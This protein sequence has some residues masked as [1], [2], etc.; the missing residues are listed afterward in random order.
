M[1]IG[2]YANQIWQ[3]MMEVSSIRQPGI[4]LPLFHRITTGHKTLYFGYSK[5]LK[6]RFERHNKGYIE[7]LEKVRSRKFELNKSD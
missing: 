5:D 2:S 3:N 6:L 4:G 7:V 1:P